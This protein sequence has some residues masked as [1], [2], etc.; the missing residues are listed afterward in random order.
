MELDALLDKHNLVHYGI[1]GMHWGVRRNLGSDGRVG[2]GT[3]AA[4]PSD[5]HAKTPSVHTPGGMDGNP[6]TS[7]DH[8]R[9]TKALAKAKERGTASLSN[10][11]LKAIANRVEAEKKFHQLTTD[12]KSELQKAVDQMRLEK[13]YR[14]LKAE[15]AR[16]TRS[17][18]RKILDAMLGAGM[19]AA[20]KQAQSYGEKMAKD[21]ISQ[22]TAGSVKVKPAKKGKPG[23][24][25]TFKVNGNKVTV[26]PTPVNNLPNLRNTP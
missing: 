14:Q 17:T 26:T 10:E 5:T 13:D 7:A 19:D 21:L 18:G 23:S 2:A 8:E 3:V 16:A 20:Q 11:E 25:P 24:K 9:A 6:N 1:K 12:Q 22:M 15:R 4:H